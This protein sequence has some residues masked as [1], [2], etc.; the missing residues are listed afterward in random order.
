M[1][2]LATYAPSSE[3]ANEVIGEVGQAGA[4]LRTAGY[5]ILG[6]FIWFHLDLW[7]HNSIRLGAMPSPKDTI[8]KTREIFGRP[9][10]RNLTID[11]GRIWGSC[12]VSG[13]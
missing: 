9:A 10:H 3:A 5:T 6:G 4:V 1:E 13:D 7:G 12:L 8:E 11:R 2:F